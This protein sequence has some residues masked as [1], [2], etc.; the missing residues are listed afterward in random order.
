LPK[1]AQFCVANDEL[2]GQNESMEREYF[3]DSEALFERLTVGVRR[4]TKPVAFLFGSAITAPPQSGQA[5]VLTTNEI[6]A[7][8]RAEFGDEAQETAFDN[9]VRSANNRYQAAF[10]FLLGRRSQELANEIIKR[11]VWSARKTLSQHPYQPSSTTTDQICQTLDSDLEGWALTPAANSIGKLAAYYPEQFGRQLLTTNFDPLLEVAIEINGGRQF[12]TVLQ[13]DGNLSQSTAQGCHIIHLHGY[14]YGSDTLHTVRQLT[15]DRPRLKHSL[16]DLLREKTLVVCGYGGWD[17]IFTKTLMDVAL[18]DG[19]RPQILWTFKNEKPQPDEKLLE[20][21]SPALDRGRVNLYSGIDCNQFFPD[22]LARWTNSVEPQEVF[23]PSPA[24]ARVR[25]HI[26]SEPDVGLKTSESTIRSNEHNPPLVEFCVGREQ[27]I[28]ELL[29]SGQSVCFV[30]GFGGHGKSTLSAQYFKEA[31][32]RGL[33]EKFVW[34]DCKEE[35]ERFEHRLVSIIVRE[36]SGAVSGNDLSRLSIEAL[37][38]QFVRAISKSTYLFVFDNI[39]HYVDLDRNVLTDNAD[40]FLKAFLKSTAAS[41]VIFTCRPSVQYQGPDMLSLRLE[42]LSIS[43]TKE[44]FNGRGAKASEE[45]VV[46]AHAL[47][48]GHAFW[49]D[50]LAV[51]AAKAAHTE[52]LSHI[53]QRMNLRGEVPFAMLESIWDDLHENQ[54]AVLR[55]MAETVKPE[56]DVQIGEYLRFQ[57]NF[58]RVNRALRS[59][60]NQNLVVV[61]PAESGDAFELHPLVREFVQTKFPHKDRLTFIDA[62]LSVYARL[63]Q[64]YTGQPQEAILESALHHWTENAEICSAAGKYQEAFNSLAAVSYRFIASEFPSEYARVAREL[65]RK[66]DWSEF[67]SYANFDGVFGT[68]VQILANLDRRE[69][70]ESLL[71][72]YAGTVPSRDARY[73][74]YCDLR[75]YVFWVQQRYEQAIEWG[76]RGKD[77]REKSNVDTRFDTSHNLALAQRDAGI[78]DPALRYFLRG[79]ELTSVIDPDEFDENAAPQFYGNIGRCLHLIGQIEPALVCYRKSAIL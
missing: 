39:D 49:L 34:V 67:K 60:R 51:Q 16:S 57:M 25:A 35:S 75:C 24:S 53:L 20:L 13:R 31:R 47:T 77:L 32:Q 46:Q 3:Y 62:I 69:E 45:D 5:G 10:Q 18:D 29:S 42:G 38:E 11:A 33:Y 59:L 44:L 72:Q 58:N 1:L 14:W 70:V 6:V 76:A 41:R 28:G 64:L 56:T 26:R 68:L 37:S 73:I 23:R 19:A 43:A 30:T 4:D 27:E 9:F 40:S 65:F 48:G 63:M 21:L 66:I 22:L 7:L 78:I 55:S 74:N 50:L 52:K 2:S 17:D 54:K 8:I 79:K 36:L 71:S 15:Q 61:R 12:R